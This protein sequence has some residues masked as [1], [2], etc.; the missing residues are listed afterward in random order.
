MTSS[1]PGTRYFIR[2]CSK[3]Y[4]SSG[5][6]RVD[7]DL[8]LGCIGYVSAY[9][10]LA[11]VMLRYHHH[12]PHGTESVSAHAVSAHAVSAHAVSAHVMLLLS[13][14]LHEQLKQS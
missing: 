8:F 5:Y 14:V 4:I 3:G 9:R 1:P 2:I 7:V 12:L 6:V 11:P 10:L 13:G